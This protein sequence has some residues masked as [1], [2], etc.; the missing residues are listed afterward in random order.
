MTDCPLLLANLRDCVSHPALVAN[1]VLCDSK[2]V[3]FKSTSYID[4]VDAK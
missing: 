2:Q 3:R 4:F 1:F